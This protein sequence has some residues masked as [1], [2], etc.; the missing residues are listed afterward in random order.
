MLEIAEKN[1]NNPVKLKDVLKKV[2]VASTHLMSLLSDVLDLSR[3]ENNNIKLNMKPMDMRVFDNNCISIILGQLINRDIAFKTQRSEFYSPYV[4]CDNL[5]LRQIVLNVL[6][7]AVKFTPDGGTI[8]YEITELFNDPEYVTYRFV[9][10]DTGIGMSK[11]F[12]ARIWDPFSQEDEG[13]RTNYNG[14]GI[15][16]TITKEYVQMLGGTIEVESQLHV[17][18]KFT[19]TIPLQIDKNP[20]KIIKPE[21]ICKNIKDSRIL[22]VEDNELNMEIAEQLLSDQ[23]A[24]VTEAFNGLDA[25][26]KFKASSVGYYDI[27]LMDIMMPE[28]DGISAT[29]AI[30]A[31][32]RPDAQNIPIIAMTANVYDEDI[33]RTQEAGMNAHIGKPVNIPTLLKLL[34]NYIPQKRELDTKII[35]KDKE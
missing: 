23:G 29:K 9:I 4:I 8:Y 14:T 19:I 26:E 24:Y 11:D 15:G 21:T 28:M 32:Q 5:R 35:I 27:I 10:E 2:N 16:M 20:E 17:G 3:I 25:L 12:L 30:R 6:E 34:S 22:L 7:N 13:S 1:I 31:L 33:K 18:S